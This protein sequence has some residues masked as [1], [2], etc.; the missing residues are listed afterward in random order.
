M[1]WKATLVFMGEESQP[2]SEAYVLLP[3]P[4]A[5]VLS[6]VTL[7][8]RHSPRHPDSLTCRIPPM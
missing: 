3:F 6:T 1:P 2:V 7:L 8:P 5:Q 4:M